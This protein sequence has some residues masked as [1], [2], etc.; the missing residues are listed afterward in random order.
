MKKILIISGSILILLGVF[1]LVDFYC[2][3]KAIRDEAQERFYMQ[4]Q[5]FIKS[6]FW[7]TILSKEKKNDD[8][9]VRIKLYR[10][11]NI[12]N[13]HNCFFCFNF[14]NL[15]D[16]VIIVYFNENQYDQ[17]HSGDYVEKNMGDEAMKIRDIIYPLSKKK[18]T[19]FDKP[20]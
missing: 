6:G 15:Q 8:Y 19:W 16:S 20:K 11:E 3:G 17:I 1:Y 5:D 12:D 4:K 14:E 10:F 13:K 9:F 2:F 7:G 18:Y